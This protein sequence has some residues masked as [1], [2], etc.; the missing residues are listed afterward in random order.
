MLSLI[1]FFLKVTLKIFLPK[2]IFDKLFYIN[3]T[4]CNLMSYSIVIRSSFIF[5][6]IIVFPHV[7]LIMC[8]DKRSFYLFY[9]VIY[10]LRSDR[11]VPRLLLFVC[12]N[13]RGHF[14][15]LLFN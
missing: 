4:L 15:H 13:F 9:A 11:S 2:Y 12:A 10:G 6:M 3:E 7:L 1:T 14:K 5:E 8:R